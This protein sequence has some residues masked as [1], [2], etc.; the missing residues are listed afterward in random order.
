MRWRRALGWTPV[1]LFVSLVAAGIGLCAIHF[2]GSGV[3]LVGTLDS[4]QLGALLLVV[5]AA[6]GVFAVIQAAILAARLRRPVLRV[7][8]RLTSALLLLAAVPI[9]YLLMLSAAFSTVNEYRSLDI[10]GHNVVIRVFTWHHRSLDIL[11]QD[12]TFFHEVAVC[13]GPLPVDG[14]DAFSTGQY[15]LVFRGGR[16]VIRFA[17][18]PGGALTGEAV[19]GSRPGDNVSAS[20]SSS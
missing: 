9:G 14:Y 15:E 20:C 4:A 5:A 18:R 1:T 7:L 11:E 12:G 3:L 16:N 2:G 19:L 10:P 13:G 8:V 6:C 17:E